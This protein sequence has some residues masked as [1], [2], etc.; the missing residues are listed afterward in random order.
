LLEISSS[1]RT[2]VEVSRYEDKADSTNKAITP[3][4]SAFVEHGRLV[5]EGKCEDHERVI[6]QISEQVI[7]QTIEQMIGRQT[8]T[9]TRMRKRKGKSWRS[10]IRKY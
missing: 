10:T 5:T 1:G 3:W 9:R 6:D 2:G 4:R 8:R 7:E